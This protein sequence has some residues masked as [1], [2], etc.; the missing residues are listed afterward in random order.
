MSD[1]V[2]V[3]ILLRSQHLELFFSRKR[4]TPDDH[5][6]SLL[7]ELQALILKIKKNKQNKTQKSQ[8][9]WNPCTAERIW[10]T[11]KLGKLKHRSTESLVC[12][13]TQSTLK[14]TH[15]GLPFLCLKIQDSSSCRLFVPHFLQLLVTG[16]HLTQPLRFMMYVTI[17]AV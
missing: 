8:H 14:S 3:S 9:Y 16:K 12:L 1:V 2:I 4:S 17:M 11:F 5:D 6:Y 7:R 10:V 15:P 13:V